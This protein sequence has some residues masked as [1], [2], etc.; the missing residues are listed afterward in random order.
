M[1]IWRFERSSSRT[2]TFFMLPYCRRNRQPRH[3]AATHDIQGQAA[4]EWMCGLSKTNV[5]ALFLRSRLHRRKNE[6]PRRALKAAR[7][8]ITESN[9][10]PHAEA[11]ATSSPLVNSG[12]FGIGSKKHGGV[13]LARRADQRHR[14]LR[15]LMRYTNPPFCKIGSRA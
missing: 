8:R 2:R 10:F 7:S 3:G 1:R 5:C 4:P 9:P 6:P 11:E 12:G 14:P 15:R 13:A